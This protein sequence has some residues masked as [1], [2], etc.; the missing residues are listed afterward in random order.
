[1]AKR[2]VCHLRAMT[3]C[4]STRWVCKV[5]NASAEARRDKRRWIYLEAVKRETVGN[6]SVVCR[7]P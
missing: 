2:C 4:K 5:R 3:A 7:I 6:P 1:M